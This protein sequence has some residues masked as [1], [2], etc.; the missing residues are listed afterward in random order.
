MS[1]SSSDNKPD[2]RALEE[3]WFDV[4]DGKSDPEKLHR[5]NDSLRADSDLR[6]HLAEMLIGDVL[7]EK[8]LKVNSFESAFRGPAPI[9]TTSFGHSPWIWGTGVVLTLLALTGLQLFLFHL[10]QH[11]TEK[12]QTTQATTDQPPGVAT[13][14]YLATLIQS[15]EAVWTPPMEAHGKFSAG[16]YRLE[17]G[18]ARLMMF[19]GNELVIDSQDDTTEFELVSPR[20]VL[21]KSGTLIA[22]VHE[23]EIGFTIETP[24]TQLIDVGTEFAVTVSQ[25]GS[26][27]EVLEGA[28][29]VKPIVGKQKPNYSLFAS[30]EAIWFSDSGDATGKS[31]QGD[32]ARIREI[33]KSVRIDPLVSQPLRCSEYFDDA[34][35]VGLD[36]SSQG[37]IGPWRFGSFNGETAKLITKPGPLEGLPAWLPD[38]GS[39]YLV[40]PSSSAHCRQLERPLNLDEDGNYYI[41][42][43]I[44]KLSVA[45]HETSKK[46]GV[47]LTL[48]SSRKWGTDAGVGFSLDGTNRFSVWTVKDRFTGGKYGAPNTT[49]FAVLKIAAAQDSRDNLFLKVYSQNDAIDFVEPTAWD[50]MGI[51]ADQNLSLDVL[52]TWSRESCFALIDQ[53]RLGDTWQSVVPVR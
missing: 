24:T 14:P 52:A 43:I 32:N 26:Q 19:N 25:D 4:N 9:A 39:R 11:S 35:P 7:L 21:L 41:S 28:V 51:P 42:L 44:Q 12:T 27:V 1:E 46:D 31:M 8:E 47:G 5:L 23:K 15:D 6:Q 48:F 17:S 13:H 33:Q 34:N 40:Q 45:E 18:K 29:N 50:V 16:N 49:Y 2:R 3:L 53:V 37:W 38:V 10:N 36:R 22:L 20:L 30:K